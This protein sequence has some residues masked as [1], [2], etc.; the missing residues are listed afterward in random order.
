[1]SAIV[2]CLN[3]LFFYNII[4]FHWQPAALCSN[5]AKSCYDCIVLLVVAL[6]FY[7]LGA[8]QPNIF[9]MIS[10]LHQMQHIICTM[11]GDSKKAGSRKNWGKPI[12][13]ISQ[14][15]GAGLHI[16]AAVS[17]PLFELLQNE[18]FLPLSWVQSHCARGNYL[19]LPLLMTWTY[20]LCTHQ[21][22]LCRLPNTCKVWYLHGKA[23]SMPPE[24][25]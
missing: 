14:G 11:F 12:A 13:G 21:T 20:V 7:R 3:K 10:T 18:G 6:C 9:S 19:V 16:W 25:S 8:S 1:M 2:Q 22:T 4:G 23:Y 15:N 17:L 24:G 5:N